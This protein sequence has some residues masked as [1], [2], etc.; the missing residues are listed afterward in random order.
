MVSGARTWRP[1]QFIWGLEKTGKEEYFAFFGGTD[2]CVGERCAVV[3]QLMGEFLFFD[4]GRDVFDIPLLF[5]FDVVFYVSE[6]EI[7]VH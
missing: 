3:V 2:G 7:A 6:L 4:Y 1:D 5:H